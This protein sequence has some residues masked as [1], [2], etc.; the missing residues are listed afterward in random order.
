MI[1]EKNAHSF[2][3]K[4]SKKCLKLMIFLFLNMQYLQKIMR[5]QIKISSL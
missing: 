2:R 1:C 5:N 4:V 3:A